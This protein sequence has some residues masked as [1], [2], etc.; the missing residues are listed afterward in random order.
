MTI[1]FANN[2]TTT[3]TADS[4]TTLSV[5]ASTGFPSPT[6][7]DFFYCTLI[8]N[9]DSKI[10]IVKV[11]AVSGTN[12]TVVRAQEDTTQLAFIAGDKVELRITAA[13][14]GAM[15]QAASGRVIGY[16]YLDSSGG[17]LSGTYTP[18]AGY[19]W[20]EVELQAAGGGGAGASTTTNAQAGG[21]GGGGG[22]VRFV[23]TAAQLGASASFTLAAGGAGGAAGSAG[24]GASVSSFAGWNAAGG[25]GGAAPSPEY[26]S[27]ASTGGAG[28]G[29][30][31]GTG[32]LLIYRQGAA[33]APGYWHS[34]TDVLGG[35]GGDSYL[36]SGGYGGSRVPASSGSTVVT[37]RGGS[38]Y[39]GGGGGGGTYGGGSA[40]GA[41]GGPAFLRIT[42]YSL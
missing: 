13:G 25:A 26:T 2:A 42:A 36:G 31:T 40:D 9:S 41:A 30:G 33:G 20:V 4:G 35:A 15:L 27:G 21:G 5:T 28:G 1:L 8:R 38:G 29:Y 18:P 22:Y 34:A 11:T 3:L 6:A 24:T 17:S 32:T 14:L 10:E 16:N 37:A 12:W 23:M 39:G 19:S 7:P